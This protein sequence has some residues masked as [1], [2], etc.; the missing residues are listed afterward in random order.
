M[1]VRE[2]T[3]RALAIGFLLVDAGNGLALPA[4]VALAHAFGTGSIGYGA[5][6]ALWGA[7]GLLGGPLAARVLERR[8]PFA[9]LEVSAAGLALAF[10]LTAAAPWFGLALAAL[11]VGG[12]TMSVAGVAEDVLFQRQVS[13]HV[14][15]RVYAARI[16]VIQVSLAVPL[17]FSGFLV[18]AAGPRAVYA[19]AGALAACGAVALAALM[20]R[21]GD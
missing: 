17:L 12:A 15:S 20:R 16:A 9:V 1:L 3:L 6:V 8:R 14:R 13:D 11:A 21:A 2:P 7:G 10:V 19:A 18:N 4:E 5:L